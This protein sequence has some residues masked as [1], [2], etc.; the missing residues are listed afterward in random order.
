MTDD[1]KK[2]RAIADSIFDCL[3]KHK[4]RNDQV[5]DA[6]VNV[7]VAHVRFTM[8][9]CSFRKANNILADVFQAHAARDSK[10]THN[11]KETI[12]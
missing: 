12:Q 7:L 10:A 3:E 2:V 9:R 1:E 8:E 5:F 6:L 4:P 11:A